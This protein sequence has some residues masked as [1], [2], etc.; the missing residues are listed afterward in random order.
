MLVPVK[1][2]Y[3]FLDS[4]YLL[5]KCDVSCDMSNE[6]AAN[7]E[8]MKLTWKKSYPEHQRYKEGHVER[9]SAQDPR[10]FVENVYPALLVV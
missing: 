1:S 8:T 7:I 5:T 4:L 2:L 6:L 10:Q 3:P 9:T